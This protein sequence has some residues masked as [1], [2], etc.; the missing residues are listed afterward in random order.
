MVIIVLALPVSKF[1]LGFLAVLLEN[2]V[3]NSLLAIR[4]GAT[5]GD[6][7]SDAISEASRPLVAS[8]QPLDLPK[9][10]VN[11]LVGQVRDSLS[12]LL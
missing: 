6:L 7:L 9:S 1:L 3:T 2:A 11:L 4:Q 5:L 12:L 8:R 10:L